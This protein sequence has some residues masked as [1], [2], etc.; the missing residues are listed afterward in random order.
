MREQTKIVFES[1]GWASVW[2]A[3]SEKA[4][5]VTPKDAAQL[6]ESMAKTLEGRPPLDPFWLEGEA[7]LAKSKVP[8][9]IRAAV[10]LEWLKE[11]DQSNE[12]DHA[13][14]G[15]EVMYLMN[16]KFLSWNS[17]IENSDVKAENL[18]ESVMAEI[19]RK[20]IFDWSW[21]WECIRPEW[22]TTQIKQPHPPMSAIE[23]LEKRRLNGALGKP[24]L[25]LI[26][27]TLDLN[28]KAISTKIPK[29]LLKEWEFEILKKE[30]EPKPSSGARKSWL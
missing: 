24:E 16:V 5:G 28:E 23:A 13:R 3:L 10:L 26:R 20:E 2:K 11:A 8:Q 18:A 19:D 27:T 30:T 4:K 6:A 21:S 22:W 15:F 12:W 17:P 29:N 9:E 14:I 7:S 25:N 1:G